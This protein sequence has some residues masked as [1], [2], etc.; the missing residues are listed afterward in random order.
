MKVKNIRIFTVVLEVPSEAEALLPSCASEPGNAF[1]A[2]N[3]AEQNAAFQD[4][5][6]NLCT[7]QVKD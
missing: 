4:I 1:T 7:L 2:D 5:V 3:S 6:E